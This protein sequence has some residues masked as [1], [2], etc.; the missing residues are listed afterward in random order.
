[1]TFN[2]DAFFDD[3]IPVLEAV[4]LADASP[5]FTDRPSVN[6]IWLWKLENVVKAL[7]DYHG[8]DTEPRN[9]EDGYDCRFMYAHRACLTSRAQVECASDAV[10]LEALGL[11]A[12]PL[13]WLQFMVR[14]F[15]WCIMILGNWGWP[16]L[17]GG[18]LVTDFKP[19]EKRRAEAVYYFIGL[20][21][22]C[23]VDPL[24]EVRAASAIVKSRFKEREG[25][26]LGEDEF[27]AWLRTRDEWSY[28]LYAF[29][30]RAVETPEPKQP[31]YDGAFREQ[32]AREIQEAAARR[33]RYREAPRT[34][35][36]EA[37]PGPYAWCNRNTA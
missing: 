11:A 7:A 13:G 1:M 17:P 2:L 8:K 21:S 36:C 4:D 12:P 19:E 10:L 23:G 18:F 29:D 3:E 32:F 28:F 34:C 27:V 33:R 15:G 20:M 35:T 9:G 30:G 37:K 26:D 24:A 25:R 31:A 6:D 14:E 22:E 5:D 16:T